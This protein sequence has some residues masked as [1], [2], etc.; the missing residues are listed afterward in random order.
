VDALNDVPTHHNLREDLRQ[1]HPESFTWALTCCERNAADAEDVLQSVYLKVLAGDAVFGG[2]S[3][4]KTW[5]FGVILNTARSR[6]RRVMRRLS[7]LTGW[8]HSQPSTDTTQPRQDTI[9]IQQRQ[10]STILAA[11]RHL[12]PRQREILELVFFHD[13]TLDEAAQVT[14]HRI[15]TARTHYARGKQRLLALLRED[16]TFEWEP[17]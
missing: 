16:P 2:R 4:F 10:R 5:L 9:L 11:I 8:H 14:G 17:A 15:G 3:S 12:S 1:L 7:L 6:R 13:L